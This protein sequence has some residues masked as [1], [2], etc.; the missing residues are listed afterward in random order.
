MIYAF[1]LC[2]CLYTLSLS[3][4]HVGFISIWSTLY[5]LIYLAATRLSIYIYL[6]IELCIY[7][8]TYCS[9]ILIVWYPCKYFHLTTSLFY[10]LL[11][12]LWFTIAMCYSIMMLDYLFM[13]YSNCLCV[14]HITLFMFLVIHQFTCFS[15]DHHYYTIVIHC[16]KDIF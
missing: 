5:T 12:G 7:L 10:H 9:P 2:I 8:L 14:I 15:I 3:G 1:I 11:I 13:V 6:L 4:V 16:H